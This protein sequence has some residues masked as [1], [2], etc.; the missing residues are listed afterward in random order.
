MF[1]MHLY[2]CIFMMVTIQHF[3]LIWCRNWGIS[4]MIWFRTRFPRV[5]RRRSEKQAK[6]NE[7]FISERL[8]Q[9]TEGERGKTRPPE[10]KKK[11]E[12]KEEQTNDKK[13][14]KW[15]ERTNQKTATGWKE[16]RK[17]RKKKNRPATK[18]EE[19]KMDSK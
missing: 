10:N 4:F 18:R 11:K 19:E 1:C 13:T 8:D 17:K 9:A 12:K 6:N 5:P 2:S 16:R 7:E 15:K 3:M 14:E